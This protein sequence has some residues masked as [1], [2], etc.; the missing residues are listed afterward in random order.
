MDLREWIGAGVHSRRNGVWNLDQET[1]SPESG[2]SRQRVSSIRSH[3]RVG[4]FW[5]NGLRA[6]SV[7]SGD[8]SSR[9]RIVPESLV[10]C[11]NPPIATVTT[12]PRRTAPARVCPCRT[13]PTRPAPPAPPSPT[14][15]QA[16]SRLPSPAAM[17]STA[18]LH[19][20]IRSSTITLPHVRPTGTRSSRS[21]PQPAALVSCL[22]PIVG[23]L[24]PLIGI[25]D[26][27]TLPRARS[28]KFGRESP[29][30]H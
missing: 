30:L 23:L 15:G 3:R 27:A 21:H 11:L 2:W 9:S 28:H 20:S 7:R 14:P 13:A 29:A 19:L 22:V 17:P 1:F 8:R 16:R 25:P 5:R 4:S 18:A 12:I 6:S 26:L 24:L 10:P